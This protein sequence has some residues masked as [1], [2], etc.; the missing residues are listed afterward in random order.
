MTQNNSLEICRL[1]LDDNSKILNAMIN[2]TLTTK[3]FD[4]KL[5]LKVASIDHN[6]A[7]NLTSLNFVLNQ[8]KFF[9][10]DNVP[11]YIGTYDVRST[12]FCKI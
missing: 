7:N 11:S 4:K 9:F 12:Y 10:L 5:F 6:Q 3:R 1:T 2:F 8:R